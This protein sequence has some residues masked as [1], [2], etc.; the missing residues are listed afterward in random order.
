MEFFAGVG[1]VLLGLLLA[2]IGVEILRSCSDLAT[3]G[4]QCTPQ[5]SCA[6]GTQSCQSP[7]P[8]SHAHGH[9]PRKEAPAAAPWPQRVCTGHLELPGLGHKRCAPGTQSLRSFS[10]QD[11]ATLGARCT[12]FVARELPPAP[13]SED[14]RQSASSGSQYSLNV[15]P[16]INIKRLS[17][18]LA[19]V[20]EKS[21]VET[22]VPEE[23]TPED[24]EEALP[25]ESRPFKLYVCNLPESTDVAELSELFK[26]YGSVLSVEANNRGERK[27]V[28]L[29]VTVRDVPMRKLLPNL[30]REGGFDTVLEVPVPEEIFNPMDG[31]TKSNSRSNV[32]T[33]MKCSQVS[34][35]RPATPLPGAGGGGNSELPLLLNV[36]GALLIPLPV[37]NDT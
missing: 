8:C 37:Q 31:S 4:A 2:G 3:L 33:W 26:P 16:V 27:E 18:I 5:I 32:K 29:P 36:V 7:I 14:S 22:S 10:D 12:P 17:K 34:A 24:V 15:F 30:D 19:V 25:R 9:S 35:V 20:E 28:V 6:S 13:P 23:S 11:L 1:M 21:T